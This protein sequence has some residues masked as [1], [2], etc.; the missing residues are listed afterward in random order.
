MKNR[1][2]RN[3][4]LLS[5]VSKKPT[6]QAGEKERMREPLLTIGM[7][8]HT[9]FHGTYFTIQS[10]RTHHPEIMEDVEIIVIDN[11]PNSSHG[12]AVKGV[13]DSVN[14]GNPKYPARYIPFENAVGTSASR[15]QI[16][17]EGSGK[18]IMSVDCHVL[19]PKGSLGTLVKYLK[20]NPNCSDFMHGS[21]FYDNLQNYSTHFNDQWRSEMWGTWGTAWKAPNGFHF[22]SVKIGTKPVLID[23]KDG[24]TPVGIDELGFSFNAD[25][26]EGHEQYLIQK[27]CNSV[28]GDPDDEVFDIPGQGLGM[29]LVAKEHWP[30]FNIHARGFG[31]E[32]L[33]V[34]G[35]HRAQGKRVVLLPFLPWVH[36][37]ARP[38]GVKYPLTLWNKVRNYVLEFSE[39]KWDLEPIRHHFVEEIGNMSQKQW[40]YLIKDPINHIAYPSHIQSVT[41]EVNGDDRWVHECSSVQDIHDRLKKIPR[42]FNEHM[43]TL[44]KYADECETVLEFSDRRETCIPL[45]ASKAKM[46][47][48]YNTEGGNVVVQKATRIAENSDDS[49]VIEIYTKGDMKELE[50]IRKSDLVFIDK[51]SNEKELDAFMGPMR[52]QGIFKRYIVLHDVNVYPELMG[53]AVKFMK[54]YPEWSVVEKTNTQHGLLVLSC[55]KRDK[56]PLPSLGTKGKNLFQAAKNYIGDGLKNSTK[57]EYEDRLAI[58]YEC[59]SRN[60]KNCGECGCFIEAKAAIRSSECPLAKWPVVDPKKGEENVE[61]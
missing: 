33:Y 40:E 37:F 35:K 13:I 48:S 11:N 61:D 20:D 29:F 14:G 60:D 49:R 27:G 57:E 18:F 46:I 41:G 28:G 54:E 4:F 38:D 2:S 3:P 23:L 51:C 26:W 53:Y 59:P 21:L 24:K 47:Q 15:E 56:K 19:F 7:A 31:G 52:H 44:K 10:L 36:R 30:G 43:D 9:D 22:S 39:L 34:H 5:K 8:T 17:K 6:N 32:E 25:K 58:C 12:K 55:D 1:I 42:D 16:F 50:K 45:L